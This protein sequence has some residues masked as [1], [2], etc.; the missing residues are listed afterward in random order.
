MLLTLSEKNMQS[1]SWDMIY[2]QNVT[3]FFFQ[4]PELPENQSGNESETSRDEY[5]SSGSEEL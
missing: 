5:F 4:L 3:D 1:E 2:F